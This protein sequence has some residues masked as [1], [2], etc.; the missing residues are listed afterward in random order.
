LIPSSFDYVSPKSLSVAIGLLESRGEGAKIIAGGQSLIPL[1][2]LRLASPSVLIDLGR[3]PGLDYMKEER[4]VLRI[5]A[6]TRMSDVAASD[7]IGKKY[8]IIHD[9]AKV[10]AD[11]L[12]RN[13]GTMGGNVSHG[14]PT[15]DMPAV[16]L[17]VGA[18]FVATGPS[19]ERTIA[20]SEF[21]LD[22]FS[23]ALEHDEI[24]TEIRVPKPSSRSGGSYLKIE[25]K[26][27]DF[28][29]AAVAVQIAL[30]G[31]GV[32]QTVGIGLTAV[33]PKAI[34]ARA[35]EDSLVGMKPA[36]STSVKKAA[37]LA[38]D[39]SDP[40]SDIRGSADYKRGLVKLLVTKGVKVAYAR[41]QGRAST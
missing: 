8:P 9:A 41:S 32:C 16:M 10:I 35:A 30:S 13:L 12:V 5:G 18:D 36:D 11:P 1:M 39:A 19:G 3:I 6:M 37:Q 38:A 4:G 22:S 21:F 27:A 31:K 33:G 28:A 23:V 7:M 34:K 14:D 15:N 29:T 17:A 2:K 24:L 25:Q 40:A 20:A 26:V